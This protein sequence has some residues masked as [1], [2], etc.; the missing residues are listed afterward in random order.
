ML[1]AGRS[2]SMPHRTQE[3][4]RWMHHPCP[5]VASDAS[6]ILYPSRHALPRHLPPQGPSQVVLGLLILGVG[7]LDAMARMVR[8]VPTASHLHRWWH[9]SHWAPGRLSSRIQRPCRPNTSREMWGGI[10]S[11]Y[12][13]PKVPISQYL[14][15]VAHIRC[16]TIN[17][18]PFLNL[19]RHMEDE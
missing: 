16:H 1:V 17:N 18:S 11:S 9:W 19:R 14:L 7:G 10:G 3:T 15:L 5:L 13:L 12:E 4:R 8:G 6:A 2:T